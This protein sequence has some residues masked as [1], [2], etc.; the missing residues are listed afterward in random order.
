VER[1][2]LSHND[3][4]KTSKAH[5]PTDEPYYGQGQDEESRV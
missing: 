1:K 3:I 5:E 4:G 2:E